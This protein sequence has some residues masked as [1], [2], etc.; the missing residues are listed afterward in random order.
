MGH[1]KFENPQQGRLGFVKRP[2]RI[3][4]REV[5]ARGG[6]VAG[7]YGTPGFIHAGGRTR[8]SARSPVEQAQVSRQ[9]SRTLQARHPVEV[10]PITISHREDGRGSGAFWDHYTLRTATGRNTLASHRKSVKPVVTAPGQEKAKQ[11]SGRLPGERDTPGATTG[12]GHGLLFIAGGNHGLASETPRNASHTPKGDAV[13]RQARRDRHETFLMSQARLTGRPVLAVCGGSWRVLESFGGSTRGVETNTHQTRQ[14]PYLTSKGAVAKVA[15]THAV[16]VMPGTMVHHAFR[17]DAGTTPSHVNSAHWA[18]AEESRPGQ[19]SGVPRVGF[20]S[21]PL[22]EVS[23]RG[24]TPH[25]PPYLRKAMPYHRSSVEAF[26]SS[27]GAPVMG[28]QW[29][30]EAYDRGF[31]SVE[32]QANGRLLNWMAK[33][34]DA[35]EARREMTADFSKWVGSARL[36]PTRLKQNAAFMTARRNAR[37]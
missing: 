20:P 1:R 30:P 8:E 28:I 25:D 16:D 32:H 11:F 19:L 5:L 33:A 7:P 24:P 37:L 27:H 14:M 12:V 36:L 9:V 17:D 21:R 31:S 2:Q 13:K 3:S 29:H 4:P 15:S 26:E 6:I 23:A 10:Q 35:Y 22:L 34:G 18:V